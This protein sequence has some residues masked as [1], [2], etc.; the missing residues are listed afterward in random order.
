MTNDN[1][2]PAQLLRNAS[3]SSVTELIDAYPHEAYA[4]D[5]FEVKGYDVF[6]VDLHTGEDNPNNLVDRF[7]G[8]PRFST[9][10]DFYEDAFNQFRENGLIDRSRVAWFVGDNAVFFIQSKHRE[11]FAP[12]RLLRVT[13]YIPFDGRKTDN[14]D[15]EFRHRLAGSWIAITMGKLNDYLVDDHE[16]E[17]D[18]CEQEV[19]IFRDI[20]QGDGSL[21]ESPAIMMVE[22]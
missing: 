21:V 3:P 18:D 8:E 11:S 7:S 4:C 19:R 10:Y 9:I 16:L 5:N 1:T 6:S 15:V 2:T 13:A 12:D 20:N 17:N 22:I 14:R